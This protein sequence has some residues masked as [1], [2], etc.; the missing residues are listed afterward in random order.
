MTDT[1]SG[2]LPGLRAGS[3]T[4]RPASP[5]TGF[6]TRN[7]LGIRQPASSRISAPAR[8]AGVRPAGSR[9]FPPSLTVRTWHHRPGRKS[10]CPDKETP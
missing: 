4:A 1:T 7:P 3:F 6:S 5:R 8:T 10:A 9:R 2:A